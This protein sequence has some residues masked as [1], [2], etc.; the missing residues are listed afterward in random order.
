MNHFLERN[1]HTQCFQK[2]LDQ[3]WSS[4]RKYGLSAHKN[5]A[6]ILRKLQT[7][8]YWVIFSFNISTFNFSIIVN[9][10][11]CV[12]IY[13]LKSGRINTFRIL[14]HSLT[15]MGRDQM[16]RRYHCFSGSTIT[17]LK[18]ENVMTSGVKLLACLENINCG[19]KYKRLLS[20]Q[21]IPKRFLFP[22]FPNFQE[23]CILLHL[24][25]EMQ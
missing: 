9:S 3:F 6:F 10:C 4:S 11:F 5:K 16:K 22:G 19:V 15:N 13:S 14:I 18:E 12:F 24:C 25:F 21:E 17:K 20:N 2:G 1:S 7:K 8:C 23:D